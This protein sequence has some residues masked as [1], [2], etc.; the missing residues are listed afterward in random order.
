MQ[1]LKLFNEESDKEFSA[2][3]VNVASVP[4]LSPFRYPG[5]KTWFIPYIRQWLSPYIRQKHNLIPISPE[6]FIEPFLGGG[7]ISLTVASE[8]LAKKTTM[9]EIDPDVAAVWHTVL[10]IEDGKW[11]A[12]RILSYSLTIENVEALLNDIPITVRERAFQTIVRNRV[13]RGG[14][15]APGSGLMK[16]G[17]AGKGLLSRW[18]PTTLAKRIRHITALQNALSFLCDDGLTILATHVSNPNAVFFLDPPYTA[19]KHGKQ[20]GKRLYAHSEL[21]H[22]Q[23]FHYASRIQGD[24]LM[25]YDNSEEVRSLARRY[26]FDTRLVPMK[27]THHINMSELVIGPNLA[28][29]TTPC[30]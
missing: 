2:G 11:L 14:I 18:Y 7:S 20:A 13:C 22:E 15:L 8:R 24:F 23:L 26:G 29:L 10:N 27:N 25:T 17:E 9:V 21:D 4:K 6:H 16:S 19:D 12:N 30:L 28:W 3:I 5:G 1:Q